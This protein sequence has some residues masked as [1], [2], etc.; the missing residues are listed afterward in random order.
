MQC[1]KPAATPDRAVMATSAPYLGH[2]RAVSVEVFAILHVGLKVIS[3][4]PHE[5]YSVLPVC[6]VVPTGS[7]KGID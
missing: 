7:L 1:M 4:L 3:V 2:A 5:G 6:H